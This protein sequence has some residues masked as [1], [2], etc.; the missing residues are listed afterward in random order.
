[1][2]DDRRPAT[3]DRLRLPTINDRQSSFRNFVQPNVATTTACLLKPLSIFG[4]FERNLVCSVRRLR[5]LPGNRRKRVPPYVLVEPRVESL[6]ALDAPFV[7]PFAVSFVRARTAPSAPPNRETLDTRG[8]RRR[9]EELLKRLEKLS[10]LGR[11][12]GRRVSN[13]ND[14]TSGRNSYAL[15]SATTSDRDPNDGLGRES[16]HEV[17]RT[18]PHKFSNSGLTDTAVTA[19]HD[20]PPTPSIPRKTPYRTRSKTAAARASL[21]KA[22]RKTSHKTAYKHFYKF[23]PRTTVERR[24]TNPYNSTTHDATYHHTPYNT[25]YNTAFNLTCNTGYN[26]THKAVYNT[27]RKSVV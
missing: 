17:L 8:K 26:A 12:L 7:V 24:Y 18:L 14:G 11:Q 22:P 15:R 23:A 20:R 1:M 3:A 10:K 9:R 16:T 6:H 5:R 21:Y 4:S 27:D 2:N 25:V 19:E 13:R